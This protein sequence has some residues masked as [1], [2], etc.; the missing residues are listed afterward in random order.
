[1]KNPQKYAIFALLVSVACH[2]KDDRALN[3]EQQNYQVVQEGAAG[4]TTTALDS[5]AAG[6]PALTNTNADTTSNFTLQ[7]GAVAGQAGGGT[8]AASMPQPSGSGLGGSYVAPAP[9][10]QRVVAPSARVAA[11]S[12]RAPVRTPAAS[13]ESQPAS[14]PMTSA[15][16]SPQPSASTTSQPVAQTTTPTNATTGVTTTSAPPANS[17][18][19]GEPTT[20]HT[21][22]T[23]KK[24]DA[25]PQEKKPEQPAE[26]PAPQP[27]SDTPSNP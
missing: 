3:R 20:T 5:A 14:Q 19:D 9:A 2:S 24:D 17:E 6:T 8:L 25:K 1:M 22:A 4:V 26:E 13:Y 7:P 16:S 18:S 10:P 21:D 12:D 15:A 11:N 23:P 27:P